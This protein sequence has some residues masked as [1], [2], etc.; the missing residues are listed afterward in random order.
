MPAPRVAFSDKT[1]AAIPLLAKGQT[2]VRDAELPGFFILVGT[3]GK[4][5]MV[6]ADLWT[7]RKR[8]SVRVKIGEVDRV[9]AREAR[10]KAKVLLGSIANGIDPRP[11]ADTPPPETPVEGPTLRQ[12]WESYRTSHMER[13]ARSA[14]TIGN[15]RDHLE[16][17]LKDWLD[18]PLSTLGNNP[19]L[20]KARHDQLSKTNGPYIANGCMRSLRAIYNHARKTARTL[21]VENPVLAVDWNSESRRN[22]ALGPSDLGGWFAELAKVENPLRREFHLFLLLS[23]SR[24][25]AIKRARLEHLDL[26]RRL[27]RIPKPKGGADKAFD[28]PL[29]RQMIRCLIRAIRLGRV[30]Y[31]IQCGTWLFPSDSAEGHIVEH[32]ERRTVLSKWGNDLR[33]TYRTLGQAAGINEVDMH[34]LMNH[35]I[36]GVNAGYIT[37][38]RLLGDHLRKQQQAISDV[39]FAA[40][41]RDRVSA[42]PSL[43]WLFSSAVQVESEPSQGAAAS[44]GCRRSA[45]S[46]RPI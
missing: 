38:N 22:T 15:Y 33:Q 43:D 5:Y 12:A 18:Q 7:E 45:S 40:V 9:S 25:D 2:I 44:P 31:P 10:A 42:A 23:G 4:T 41:M 11:K 14:G 37:R 17:L 36:A 35:S 20:V 8:Q 21:P 34:L 46:K 29:S 19:A 26:R 39:A 27:L 1:A 16:R 13:K 3:R 24:P 32:K 30:M 6:Q 28:I